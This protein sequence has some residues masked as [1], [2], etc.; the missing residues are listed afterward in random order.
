LIQEKKSRTDAQKKIG[1]QLLFEIR[2]VRRE[3]LALELSEM[4][5][6]IKVGT[7]GMVAVDISAQL[8]GYAGPGTV[9]RKSGVPRAT[10]LRKPQ[11]TLCKDPVK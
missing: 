5:T 6:D 11:N 9:T 3:P 1:S 10:G 2:K 7:D 4:R 8:S